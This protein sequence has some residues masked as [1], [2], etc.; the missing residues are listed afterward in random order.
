MPGC[1][2]PLSRARWRCLVAA[3]LV[4]AQIGV[5]LAAPGA[6]RAH[7]HSAHS[8]RPTRG[9]SASTDRQGFAGQKPADELPSPLVL[10]SAFAP[11]AG[12]RSRWKRIKTSFHKTGLVV[13]AGVDLGLPV[14]FGGAIMQG[15]QITPR[16][17]E[18][19]KRKVRT[20]TTGQAS[21][22]P[23]VRKEVWS[24][25]KKLR[26]HE[27]ALAGVGRGNPVYGDR[28]LI[29]VIPP[30]LSVGASRKGG[31]GF[32][33]SGLPFPFYYPMLRTAVTVY[34]SHPG[35]SKVSN[36]LL[37]Q[38][39]K[40]VAK[41]TKFAKKSRKRLQ[42]VPGVRNLPG[43]RPAPV[44]SAPAAVTE[45]TPPVAPPVSAKPPVAALS[46]PLE[47][48]PERAASLDPTAPSEPMAPVS[49]AGASRP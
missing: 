47:A 34:V 24:P 46:D 8:P 38:V 42:R 3:Q 48:Q 36:P 27:N 25:S 37:D 7:S 30:M 45:A 16:D 14:G 21:I 20:F 18:T 4:A 40:V 31:L 49:P 33:F 9:E 2:I 39:D 11:P 22:G 17:P 23:L 19:E 29:P 6:A 35:L 12:R 1:P 26:G 10:E 44:T 13:A 43:I 5:L 28:V 32:S 15:L 41:A